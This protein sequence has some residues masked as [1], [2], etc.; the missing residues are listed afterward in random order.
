MR[1]FIAPLALGAALALVAAPAAAQQTPPGSLSAEELVSRAV[2]GAEPALRTALVDAAVAS[3]QRGAEVRSALRSV[4]RSTDNGQA[5]A[6]A[7]ALLIRHAQ[8]QP[9]AVG[10]LTSLLAEFIRGDVEVK[11]GIAI[12][13]L[14]SVPAQAWTELTPVLT[15]VIGESGDETVDALCVRGLSNLGST[16]MASLRQLLQG[17]QLSGDAAAWARY[18]TTRT[19]E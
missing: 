11:R 4:A 14:G 2:G 10:S 3:N 6:T 15:Q 18:Y 16:G 19:G 7:I 5:F 8:Q 1:S 17:G 9:A 13:A 12:D